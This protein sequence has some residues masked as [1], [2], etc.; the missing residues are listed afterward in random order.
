MQEEKKRLRL[1]M[2]KKKG[3]LSESERSACAK[4][5]FARIEDSPFFQ[6][7]HY[8][9]CYFALSDEVPTV[10][11]MNKWKDKKVFLLPIV[12]GE[13][14]RF[15]YYKG[16]EAL[17]K[18]AF[19]ILEPWNEAEERTQETMDLILVPGVAFDLKGNRMGRGKGFYDR[20]L[21]QKETYKVGVCFDFQL[22]ECIPSEE[23]DVM[24]DEIVTESRHLQAPLLGQKRLGL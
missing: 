22:L 7:A 9:A 13:E 2:R 16:E 23:T 20:F 14:M 1:A 18:G 15:V 24:M 8:I 6:K 10:D 3:S 21:C 12:E 11:F 4:Q 19:G 17:K 5:L